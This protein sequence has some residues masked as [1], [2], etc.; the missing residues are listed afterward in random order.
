M[1]VE[2]AW[3]AAGAPPLWVWAVSVAA[4]ILYRWKGE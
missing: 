2:W 1:V 3:V 4:W